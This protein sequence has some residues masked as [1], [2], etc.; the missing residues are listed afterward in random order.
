MLGFKN[1]ERQAEGILFKRYYKP[2][3]FFAE[4]MTHNTSVSQDLVSEAI[5]KAYERRDKFTGTENLKAF[6]YTIVRNAAIN[7]LHTA[8]TQVND[9]QQL[10]DEITDTA[11]VLTN[12]ILLAEIVHDIYLEIENL[13]GKCKTIFKMI[14]FQGLTTETIAQTMGI[15]TQTVRTQKARAIQLIR[16]QLLRKERYA[17]ATLLMIALAH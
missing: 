6:L 8:R 14:F 12:E 10:P 17:A 16:T 11:D 2:L 3:C 5:S 4:K 13:P 15:S 9:L 1:H 7:Y